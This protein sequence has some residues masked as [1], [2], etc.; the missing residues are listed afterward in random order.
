M[1]DE[2]FDVVVLGGGAGGMP[3][4]IRAA[5]LGGR[6]AI[7]EARDLGGL[8]M[9]RGCIPFR[10][11]SAASGILES[12]SLGKEMGLNVKGVS[13][14]YASLLK[15]QT[16]LISFMRE[17]VKGLL[18]KNKVTIV[19][20]KGKLAG[21]GKVVVNGD[22][23]SYK[24]LIL[25]TGSAWM[26]PDFPGADL[27]GVMTSDGLLEAKRL[28][29]RV[30]LYG[31]SPWLVEIGQF[32]NRFGGKVTLA[33]EAKGLLS[34]ENKTI[35]TRLTKAL[36]DQG[37]TV[38]ARTGM[39]G[40]TKKKDGLHAALKVKDKEEKVVVDCVTVLKRGAFLESLG[41]ETVGLDTGSEYLTVNERMETSVKGVYAIGDLSAP[42]ERH[43]SHGASS[44]GII[45]AENAM[46]HPRSFNPRAVPRVLF[47][48]PQVACVG[49][50][51]KE[52]KDAGHEVVVGAAPL[53]MNPLGMVLAQTEGLVE[54]V[55]EKKYGELLGIHIIGQ[56]A[57][58]MIG[59]G[60][61]AIQLEATLEEL[62]QTTFP[63]PTLSEFLS[64][65][66]RSALGRPI[67]IP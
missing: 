23:L 43:Y 29:K 21:K 9:N 58:E 4:A 45:A 10:H 16:E 65:A 57:S 64:E 7:I 33:T 52:A 13:Q 62:A 47:T 12:L 26:K 54:I 8:C 44:G 55:S 27:D 19:Q 53:S 2:V 14:D 42:E 31:T 3:A 37:I 49:L 61:L 50:T 20:G 28:P 18:G 36:R 56:G 60:V 51:S 22:T 35:R 46:G 5:Q 59:Q 32:L 39:S 66:A 15:R 1:K 25:A 11:M 6:A 40:L 30:L 24:N 48:Q 63:H 67:Y 17:G 34:N 41:L 38:L